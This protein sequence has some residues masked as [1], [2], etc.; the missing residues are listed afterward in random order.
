MTVDQ[1]T[2]RSVLGHFAS[3]IVIVTSALHDRPLGLT[4]QSLIALSLDPPLVL[5]SPA[6]T[7]TT[8]PAVRA[9]GKFCVNILGEHQLQTCRKFSASGGDKFAR[10]DWAWTESRLPAIGGCI[11]YV[12]CELYET[13]EAGD[14]DIV[15][16]SVQ[17]LRLGDPRP[18]LVFFQGAYR[19]LSTAKNWPKT[20]TQES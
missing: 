19:Q 12:E 20:A 7:S 18:P 17:Q 6:K 2:F 1:R 11:A 8:W 13:H 14:H 10:V 3:G 5:F 16:G 4:V 15:I 9:T